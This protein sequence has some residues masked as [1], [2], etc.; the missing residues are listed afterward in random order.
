MPLKLTT[1]PSATFRRAPIAANHYLISRTAWP[2]SSDHAITTSVNDNGSSNVPRRK[3]IAVGYVRA[4]SLESDEITRQILVVRNS[5]QQCG[6]SLHQIYFDD[7]EPDGDAFLLDRPGMKA[8]FRAM[9]RRSFD[10]L[11]A[12]S[13]SQLSDSI[14]DSIL[15]YHAATRRA[16]EIRTSQGIVDFSRSVLDCFNDEGSLGANTQAP[17]AE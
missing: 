12:P 13:W 15:F 1:V 11:V 8:L 3:K 2:G 5:A 16:I 4:Q 17:Q 10:V 14:A 9:V 7:V 6:H